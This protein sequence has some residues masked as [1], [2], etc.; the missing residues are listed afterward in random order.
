MSHWESKPKNVKERIEYQ[1]GQYESARVSMELLISATPS[2]EA[3]NALCDANIHLQ[4]VIN[5]LERA[6]GL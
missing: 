3:R 6:K 5:A 1:L 2:G 4:E